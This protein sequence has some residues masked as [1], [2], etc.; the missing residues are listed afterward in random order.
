MLELEVAP[1][2]VAASSAAG[3]H[4]DALRTLLE[5]GGARAG[6]ELRRWR[7][8]TDA[9]AFA[10]LVTIGRVVKP[11]GRKG[12]VLIE[13][14]SDRPDRFPTLRRAFVPAPG[15]EAR[16]VAVDRLL[17]PQGPLRAEARRGRLD[18]R[19]RGAPR[20]SSCASREERARGAARGLVLPPRAPGLRVEDEPGAR[21]RRRGR[22]LETGAGAGARRRGGPGETLCPCRGLRRDGGPR[23]AAASS[24]R[25]PE[26][27]VCGLT[28]SRS[29][30]G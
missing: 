3:A 8:W 28:S 1:A 24:R 14:L 30:R 21:A 7:S 29:S 11:Q 15:G 18:R 20:R 2:T 9:R 5:R 23:R 17:A 25:A 6:A 10:D 12:E 16:E 27:A 22:L 13:P 26:L 19:G 4:R